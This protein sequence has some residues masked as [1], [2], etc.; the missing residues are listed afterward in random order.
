MK[1]PS[2]LKI[3][4]VIV[5]ILV[6]SLFIQHVQLVLQHPTPFDFDQ[7]HQQYLRDQLAS[8]QTTLNSLTDSLTA[9]AYSKKREPLNRDKQLDEDTTSTAQEFKRELL[10]RNELNRV[11]TNM[12]DHVHGITEEDYER[13][14]AHVGNRHR[15]SKFVHKLMRS[16]LKVETLLQEHQQQST[17]F[18]YSSNAV[19]VVV[20]GGSITLGHG[21]EPQS[22]RYL[23]ALE[24]W[25]NDAYPI[26]GTESQHQNDAAMKNNN[27]NNNGQQQQQHRHRVYKRG[28]HGANVSL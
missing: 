9:M 11:T 27:N 8:C 24:V 23:D 4:L 18:D 16:T 19:T 2:V 13:S 26:A 17:T 20:C 10:C 14:V 21:V 6:L 22:G 15:L 28:A 25:L 1:A 3:V 12:T 7:L 5:A